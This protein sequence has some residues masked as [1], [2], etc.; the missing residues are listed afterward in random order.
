MV[1]S[2]PLHSKAQQ[3]QKRQ[4]RLRL[5]SPLSHLFHCF[6]ST[7]ACLLCFLSCLLFS[8][9]ITQRQRVQRLAVSEGRRLGLGPSCLLLSPSS[10]PAPLLL[11]LGILLLGLDLFQG[12]SIWIDS[13]ARTH[14][15]AN[16][17]IINSDY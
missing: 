12:G 4:S 2:A 13:P 5:A 10:C 9:I 14:C 3:R 7:S 17:S 1:H 15:C 16:Q 11:L 8:K 6:S